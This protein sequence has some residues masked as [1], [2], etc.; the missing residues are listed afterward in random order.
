[1]NNFIDDLKSVYIKAGYIKI[2]DPHALEIGIRPGENIVQLSLIDLGRLTGHICPAV[3]SA[4]FIV[5]AALKHISPDEI[6]SREDYLVAVPKYDDMALVYS[7]VLDAYPAAKDDP[8]STAR[9]FLDKSLANDRENVK[10]IFKKIGNHKP[11]QITWKKGIAMPPDVKAKMIEFKKM[12]SKQ[13]MDYYDY[14]K[15]NSFVNQQVERII[16]VSSN[17][18]LDI[19]EVDYNFPGEMQF[20]LS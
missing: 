5:K 15:W 8:D 19:E 2:Y 7:Y 6:P 3:T 18:M 9:M 11:I 12:G 4:F 16:N 13:Q 17:E 1:M 20:T 10:F 14:M